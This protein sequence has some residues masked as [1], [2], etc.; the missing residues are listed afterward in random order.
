MLR[1][2]RPAQ[3]RQDSPENPRFKDV[4]V[5]DRSYSMPV[6]TALASSNAVQPS[7][8]TIALQIYAAC[9]KPRL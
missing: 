7:R 6:C 8:S 2:A 5:F 9:Q 1:A 4:L 3:A